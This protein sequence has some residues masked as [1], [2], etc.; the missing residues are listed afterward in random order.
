MTLS[1]AEVMPDL[2]LR[3]TG[4]PRPLIAK[5]SLLFVA[6]RI[7]SIAPLVLEKRF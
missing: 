1:P 4:H 5:T 7:P 2:C 3:R 6:A